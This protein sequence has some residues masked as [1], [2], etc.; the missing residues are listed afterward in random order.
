MSRG[1]TDDK[2]CNAADGA[3]LLLTAPLLR[4]VPG[5]LVVPGRAP[6]AKGHQSYWNGG[7]GQ[8]SGV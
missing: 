1:L 7:S 4:S 6:S 8:E 3:A 2:K 5:V